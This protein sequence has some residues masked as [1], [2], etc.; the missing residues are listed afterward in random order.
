MLPAATGGANWQGGA[1]DPETKIY[2]IYSVTL[3]TPLG[4]VPTD[5]KRSDMAYI[6]GDAPTRLRHRQRRRARLQPARAAG[7]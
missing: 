4:L 1:F 2:Y 3:I 7:R 6:R 5:G